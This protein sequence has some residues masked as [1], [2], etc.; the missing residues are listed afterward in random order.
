M[1]ASRND[2]S[3]A[4]LAPIVGRELSA[5][6]FRHNHYVPR[7]YQERFLPD[8]RRQ[9]ELYRLDKV[10][11][12]VQDAKG[13]QLTPPPV[14]R[15]PLKDCFAQDDLYTLWFGNTSSTAL[16][17][18]FFGSLD[19][20]GR[21]AVAHWT[22]YAWQSAD[23][24]A[25]RNLLTF[26]STQKLRTPKGLDWLAAR[27]G[28]R[29]PAAI[30]AAVVQL[31]Q[32]FSSLWA[33]CVWQIADATDSPTKFIVSDHPVTVYNRAC[34]RHDALCKGAGDPDIHLNGT[35]TIFPLSLDKVLILTN[36]SWAIDPYRSPLEPRPHPDYQHDTFFSFLDIQL[37]RKLDEQEVRAINFIIKSRAYR[38]VAAAE[39]DWLFPERHLPKGKW[40]GLGGRHFLMPD[41]RSLTYGGEVMFG[42]DDDRPS[43]IF[44]AYGRTPSN[45]E[46]GHDLLPA[47]GEDPLYRF[48]GE[49]ARMFG[50]TRRGRRYDE[51]EVD[52]DEYHAYHLSLDTRGSQKR[53]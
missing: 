18:H 34:P 7:W 9:R 11:Q 41:P 38:Y 31:G 19:S 46:Y 42:Y 6:G 25:A 2:Q 30:L 33:E 35:H 8:D 37:G 4:L 13:Q 43:L 28:T 16:E 22:D 24:E 45:P 3:A 51:A 15:R 40:S 49:F 47:P 17:R 48:K 5:A 27:L 29:Q 39:E 32:L 14:S 21:D 10:G 1:A 53:R 50:P 44:D 36:R 12:T 20:R 23:G 26:M 52:T